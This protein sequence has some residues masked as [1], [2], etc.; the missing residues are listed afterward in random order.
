MRPSGTQG[1]PRDQ[2]QRPE[3]RGHKPRRA[4]LLVAWGVARKEFFIRDPQTSPSYRH[5]AFRLLASG[6]VRESIALA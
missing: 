4:E 2:E 5:L 1:K 3:W 6:I